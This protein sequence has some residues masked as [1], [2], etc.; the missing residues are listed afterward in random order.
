MKNIL[1]SLLILMP[2]IVSSQA[3][4][5]SSGISV[6][7]LLKDS[8]GSPLANISNASLRFTVYYLDSNSS[9][10]SITSVDDT[11]NTDDFG[12][13][14]YVV[15]IGSTAMDNLAF[16][17]GYM[18]IE[19]GTDEIFNQKLHAV[20]YATY[21][22]NG[23]PAGTILPYVG[24]D[25]P[26]GWLWCNGQTIPDDIFHYALRE[27]VGN[28]TPDL[29]GVFLR[30]TGTHGSLINYYEWG[31][32]IQG[33]Q[34]T[35]SGPALG[36]FQDDTMSRHSHWGAEGTLELDEAGRHIHPFRADGHPTGNSDNDG[37]AAVGTSGADEGLVDFSVGQWWKP[38]D[39]A[40][41]H[42]HTITGNT[43]ST[44]NSD[45]VRPVNYGVNYIIKI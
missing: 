27:I 41:E 5:T 23:Y 20:P 32:V 31:Y 44:G 40:G 4:A 35:Y 29:S 11:V 18:K 21:A 43:A 38:I 17:Q 36:A 26:S 3:I 28:T 37:H 6:Q 10:I 45:E 13:F 8:S 2:L 9:E 14:S 30:G 16:Y 39:F 22:K 12:I 34:T 42:T 33:R 7:G 25:L 1:A 24:S 15:N 19:N